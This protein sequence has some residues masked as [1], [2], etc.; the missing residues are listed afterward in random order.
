[1]VRILWSRSERPWIVGPHF[2]KR[3]VAGLVAC[4]ACAFASSQANSVLGVSRIGSALGASSALASPCCS[5]ACSWF[6]LLY[7]AGF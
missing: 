2:M 7:L 4:S 3:G 5:A 6:L 1:M